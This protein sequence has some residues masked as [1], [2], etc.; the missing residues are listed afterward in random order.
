MFSNMQREHGRPT[1]GFLTPGYIDA[2][3]S[4]SDTETESITDS[5]IAPPYS[6][7]TRSLSSCS[8]PESEIECD[9]DTSEVEGDA[10][11]SGR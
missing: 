8:P 6:P 10:D 9:T 5:V 3:D 1:K 11:T 2:S 7:I 4:E